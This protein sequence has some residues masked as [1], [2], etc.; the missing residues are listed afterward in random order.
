MSER[1]K[2]KVVDSLDNNTSLRLCFLAGPEKMQCIFKWS[3]LLLALSEYMCV[4]IRNSGKQQTLFNRESSSDGLT[5]TISAP[6]LPKTMCYQPLYTLQHK[7]TLTIC[8]AQTQ[9]LDSSQS[10]RNLPYHRCSCGRCLKMPR[11]INYSHVAQYPSR[12]RWVG[13]GLLTLIDWA[14]ISI[15]MSSNSCS[16]LALVWRVCSKGQIFLITAPEVSAAVMMMKRTYVTKRFPI[17]SL[18]WFNNFLFGYEII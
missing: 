13:G 3:I 2:Q 10:F 12:R 6:E 11:F 16:T 17:T 7:H 4:W 1:E 15:S 18:W 8:H 9:S 14:V 5:E